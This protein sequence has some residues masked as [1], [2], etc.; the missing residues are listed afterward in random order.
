[1][2][3]LEPLPPGQVKAARIAV[4]A[5]FFIHGAALSGIAS[6]LPVIKDRLH[7]SDS[8]IGSSI[9]F[10][11]LG[12][13]VALPLLGKLFAKFGTRRVLTWTIVGL[14]LSIPLVVSAQ[15]H[16]LLKLALLVCGALGASSDAAMNSVAVAVQRLYP[17]PFMSSSHGFWS[18]GGFAGAGLVALTRNFGVEPAAH[19]SVVTALLFAGLWLAESRLLPHENTSSEESPS[20]ALPRGPLVFIG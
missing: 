11:P 2:D 7:L 9:M 19:V 17:K 14:C 18:L 3:T 20:M 10:S 1:M 12:A 4:T 16:W 6:F 15:T 8:G 5:V 13:V